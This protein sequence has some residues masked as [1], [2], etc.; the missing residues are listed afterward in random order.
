MNVIMSLNP[1]TG[2][3]NKTTEE[4]AIKNIKNLLIDSDNFEVN[5][6][7][8]PEKDYGNG[9][10]AFLLYKEN[11]CHMIQMPGLPLEQVRFMNEDSQHIYDFPRL[12][13]DDSSWIW[14]VAVENIL[15][16]FDYHEREEEK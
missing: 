15:Q 10:Y 5:V 4:N 6:I 8:I 7:R 2:N 11:F 14:F 9:R 16:P 13:I 1:G 12:Y 3:L